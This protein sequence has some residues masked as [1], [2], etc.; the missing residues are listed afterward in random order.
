MTEEVK[1]PNYILKYTLQGHKKSISC[2][3][4]SPDGKWL[5][6][7]CMYCISSSLIIVIAT[8]LCLHTAADKT[9]KIWDALDGKYEQTMEGHSD[10]ISDI[11]WASDSK[12]ICSASDDF[13]IKIWD[14]AT[15]RIFMHTLLLNS[16]NILKCN[17]HI[18]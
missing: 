9:I 12:Y 4:F 17:S 5:A 14:V 15:V 2:V 8:Q 7:A 13:T 18:I 16:R 10:G 11:S 1:K 3:K 6:S